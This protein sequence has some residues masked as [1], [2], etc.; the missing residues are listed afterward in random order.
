MADSIALAHQIQEEDLGICADVQKGMASH[1]YDVGRYCV[2]R[3]SAI[4]H[5]HK[6]LAGKLRAG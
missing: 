3:E 4:H 2:R 1:T 6:L 5:F